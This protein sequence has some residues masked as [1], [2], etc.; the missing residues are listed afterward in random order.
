[1]DTYNHTVSFFRQMYKDLPPLV[2]DEVSK[3][4]KE[5]LDQVENNMSLKKDDVEEVVIKFGKAIW[6]YRKAFHEFVDLYEGKI[7]EKIF[8][9]KMPNK[10]KVEYKEFKK[11]G[12]TFRDLYSGKQA[13][14][15]DLEYRTQL[16]QALAQTRTDVKKH[17]RQLVTSSEK[18]E[19]MGKVEEH[20]EILSDIEDKL[21]Q[22]R[23]L[24][25]NEYE[26]PELVGEIK[27]Q[28]EAFEHSLAGMGSS[29]DHEEIMNAPEFFEGRKDVKEG[30]NFAG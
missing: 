4:M 14:F 10:F 9:T 6:P 8:L 3:N 27:Q 29:V 22:L 13:Q 1:M 5:A 30:R 2:P 23:D 28:I 24:A 26:H 12:H 20:K 17:V 16:H 7:G 25:D 18:D 15:F 21:D 11:E 19:Y